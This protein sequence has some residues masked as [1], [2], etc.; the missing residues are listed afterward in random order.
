MSNVD[1]AVRALPGLLALDRNAIRARFE[2]RFSSARMA[3]EYCQIYQR[4]FRELPTADSG[5]RHS[6]RL[7]P[8]TDLTR[9][10]PSIAA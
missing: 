3:T 5:C 10:A 4:M 8:A 6:P 9:E 2:A 1:E 7:P